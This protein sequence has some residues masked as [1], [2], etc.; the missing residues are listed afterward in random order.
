MRSTIARFARRVGALFVDALFLRF[1]VQPAEFAR[2]WFGSLSSATELAL[3]VLRLALV[4]TYVVGSHQRWGR[5]IGKRTFR[6]RVA[7]LAGISPPP[8]RAAFLR[9]VP[10]LLFTIIND[11]LSS[12]VMPEIRGSGMYYLGFIFPCLAIG[13]LI[14]EIVVCFRS[15]G[16]RS[17]HDRIGGTVVT[18]EAARKSA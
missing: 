9:F 8:I 17:V 15:E 3:E 4:T 7:T 13:W 14:A 2:A 1:F 10:P 11:L 18:D 12:I 5:T 6:L 16:Y